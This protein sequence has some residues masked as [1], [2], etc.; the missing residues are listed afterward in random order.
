ERGMVAA[1]DAMDE[2]IEGAARPVTSERDRQRIATR[3]AG[4]D[5]EMGRL[6]AAALDAVGSGFVD[7]EDGRLLDSSLEVRNEFP[8]ERGYVSPHL[9]TDRAA[10]Q[11]ELENC[12]VLVA[13]DTLA[14]ARQ[15]IPILDQVSREKRPLFILATGIEPDA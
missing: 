9:V 12:L 8:L 15:L 11:A 6:V 4:G 2:A 1:V 14:T 13:E 10:G 3:A 5:S 7:F